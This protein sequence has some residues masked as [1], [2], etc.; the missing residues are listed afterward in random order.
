MTDADLDD[1]LFVE[2]L[3]AQSAAKAAQAAAK[4]AQAA[5]LIEEAQTLELE[6]I[7][8]WHK[9]AKLEEKIDG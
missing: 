8:L 3:Q 6:E 9:A 4:R 7:E 5:R 1:L 2:S